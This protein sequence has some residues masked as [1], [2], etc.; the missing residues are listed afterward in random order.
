MD[1][2]LNT[3]NAD[4]EGAVDPQINNDVPDIGANT[5][6][7]V[8]SA[9]AEQK[10]VQ[11]SRTNAQFAEMRRQTEKLQ[12]DYEIAKQYGQHGIFTEEDYQK[13]LAEQEAQ[14]RGVDPEF[15]NEFTTM[16]NQL[17][18]FQREKTLMQQ[19]NNL[20]SD[21]IRGELYKTWESE[22]KQIAD[23]SNVDYVTA[24]NY[25]L[26][27]KLPDLINNQ[28]TAGQQEAIRSLTHNA[29]T[30]PG[31]LGSDAAINNKNSI[32]SMSKSDFQKL[33]EEVL[34]GERKTL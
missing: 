3:V 19:D 31:A 24:F 11:D 17:N 25:V 22:V 20:R 15:Y 12:R 27:N 26:N 8:N 16:R 1:E 30:S 13:A 9:P 2:N 29:T 6:E 7:Q 34:R 5:T 21:P 18:T 4:A 23:R 33:Q 10:P 14:E 28:K 32:A